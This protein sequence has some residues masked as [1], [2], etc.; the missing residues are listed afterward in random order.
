MLIVLCTV[1]SCKMLCTVHT[2]R[3]Q[4]AATVWHFDFCD[5]LV[6]PVIA[7][8]KVH[9]SA[10]V[11]FPTAVARPTDNCTLVVETQT[12]MTGTITVE[13]D[14]STPSNSFL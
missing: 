6:F 1:M 9:V 13:V 4:S 3:T 7:F 12:A 8:A 2:R 14:S 5:V 10:A 11:G